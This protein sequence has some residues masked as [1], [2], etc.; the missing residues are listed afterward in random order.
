MST[1]FSKKT[2]HK[3]ASTKTENSSVNKIK[4]SQVKNEKTNN[5]MIDSISDNDNQNKSV[6]QVM[7]LSLADIK[8]SIPHDAHTTA[9]PNL[10]KTHVEW[11][12]RFFDIKGRKMIEISRVSP[13]TK[14]V[15]I[16][17]KGEWTNDS[18]LDA[19]WDQYVVET[20]YSYV[21]S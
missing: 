13:N 21:K 18:G 1:I 17:N 20:R 7:V 8:K 10:M 11:R 12:W 15:Y 16:D 19:S 6:D 2:N 4:P 3:E 14:R 9:Q 5:N